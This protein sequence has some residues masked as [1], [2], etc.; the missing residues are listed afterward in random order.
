MP[1]ARAYHGMEKDPNTQMISL[2]RSK[3]REG[4]FVWIGKTYKAEAHLVD[5]SRH[6][7]IQ[8]AT[9]QDACRYRVATIRGCH[10]EMFLR[11][12][13]FSENENLALDEVAAQRL[14]DALRA[15]K[16][17]GQYQVIMKKWQLNQ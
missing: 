4:A 13:G 15:I 7:G 6:Q 16:G 10:S 8:I 1:M 9:L 5:L 12:N 17:S 11:E 14:Q 2:L 3:E